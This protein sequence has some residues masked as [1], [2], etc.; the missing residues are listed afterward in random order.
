MRFIWSRLDWVLKDVH[1][2]GTFITSLM[3]LLTA[4]LIQ[5]LVTPHRKLSCAGWTRGLQAGGLYVWDRGGGGGREQP[6]W[7]SCNFS[8]HTAKYMW[9]TKNK[10]SASV[11]L[12]VLG[13]P[14][15]HRQH[16]CSCPHC[17]QFQAAFP[18]PSPWRFPSPH[19][20]CSA[21]YLGLLHGSPP[22]GL[23]VHVECW[24]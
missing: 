5:S 1:L 19:T 2:A 13:C 20:L 10:V 16:S 24:G 4:C 22:P 6:L 17:I 8:V 18:G 15:S 3:E 14:G 9:G 12:W 21:Q 7:F 11:N 23:A